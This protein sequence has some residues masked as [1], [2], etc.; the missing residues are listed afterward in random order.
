MSNSDNLTIEESTLEKL[1]KL[2]NDSGFEQK[3]WDE[4]FTTAFNLDSS[5]SQVT[6]EKV[7]E[8]LHY[9]SF[10]EWVQNFAENLHQIWDESSARILDTS[11]NSLK[12]GQKKSAIVIG[13]GP[14]IKKHDHLELIAKSDY[15]GSIICADGALNPALEAG[16]TPEKFPKFYVLTIDTLE[17]QRKFY[18]NEL[19]KKY[20]NK[21]NGIFSTVAHPKAVLSARQ[22]GIKIHWVHP[23]FDYGEGKKSFNQ[24]SALMVRAKNHKEGLP[25]IQTGGNVGTAAWFVGWQILR[26]NVVALIGINHGWEEDDSWEKIISHG[27]TSDPEFYDNN[28]GTKIDRND[29]SFE[30]LFQK[31]HNPDFDCY[32]IV[33]PLFQFYRNALIE[34][35]SRS[36]EW[37]TTVNATEGGSIFGNR[38]N[39]MSLKKFLSEDKK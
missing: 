35:V 16:I 4:W 30:K 12:S 6:I 9:E 27:R 32:S 21:I 29:P 37:L 31:I 24:I 39:C 18:D 25:A 33:D 17:R 34:F 15:K 20:G 22:A 7:M 1:I 14:S 8:K 36:P 5:T 10:D 3:T 26:C 11:Q 19:I 28:V 13:R 38:I 23:L 2:K